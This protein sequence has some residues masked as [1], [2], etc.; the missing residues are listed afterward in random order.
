MV[1]SLVIAS[2]MAMMASMKEV[3][4]PERILTQHLNSHTK[5]AITG[6]SNSLQG[7]STFSWLYK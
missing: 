6:M 5:I 2:G 7:K 4:G 1:M 3:E